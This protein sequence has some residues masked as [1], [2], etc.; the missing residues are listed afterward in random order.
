MK[1]T[2]QPWMAQTM[3]PPL[4]CSPFKPIVKFFICRIK[5]LRF[6]R[7]LL[8]KSSKQSKRGR[9][10]SASNLDSAQRTDGRRGNSQPHN[11][12][13]PQA[14]DPNLH[15]DTS[16]DTIF[17]ITGNYVERAGARFYT[18][19]EVIPAELAVMDANTGST[20][21]S[22]TVALPYRLRKI[23]FKRTHLLRRMKKHKY[24]ASTVPL[25]VAAVRVLFEQGAGHAIR[26]QEEK[27]VKGSEQQQHGSITDGIAHIAPWRVYSTAGAKSRQAWLAKQSAATTR[28]ITNSSPKRDMRGG[29][30]EQDNA[31]RGFCSSL[32]RVPPQYWPKNY[33]AHVAAMGLYD[34]EE[35]DEECD[36]LSNLSTTASLDQEEVSRSARSSEDGMVWDNVE[37]KHHDEQDWPALVRVLSRRDGIYTPRSI[38]RPVKSPRKENGQQPKIHTFEEKTPGVCGLF[39]SIRTCLCGPSSR[40]P[41]PVAA[42]KPRV[43][44]ELVQSEQKQGFKQSWSQKKAAKIVSK[45]RE[46]QTNESEK[47]AHTYLEDTAPKISANPNTDST[48]EKSA[49]IRSVPQSRSTSSDSHSSGSTRS[50]SS[51]RL[52]RTSSYHDLRQLRFV[53]SPEKSVQTKGIVKTAVSF[54]NGTSCSAPPKPALIQDN[55]P[56]SL[57]RG[58]PEPT[59]TAPPHLYH[60]ALN[61]SPETPSPPPY[62]YYNALNPAPTPTPTLQSTQPLQSAQKD[63]SALK[64]LISPSTRA[65]LAQVDH[66]TS[67]LARAN[68]HVHFADDRETDRNTSSTRIY[69]RPAQLN[70]PLPPV[71]SSHVELPWNPYFDPHDPDGIVK[72]CRERLDAVSRAAADEARRDIERQRQ[73]RLVLEQMR[74]MEERD[75]NKNETVHGRSGGSGGGRKK[76]NAKR[77]ENPRARRIPM[78]MRVP[79]VF[80]SFPP[81]REGDDMNGGGGVERV[82]R[83]IDV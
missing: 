61:P 46:K 51:R 42:N 12:S 14:N 29:G 65:I 63:L 33:R 37:E 75:R 25:H 48:N 66:D 68:R 27:E 38:P 69:R 9:R 53:N 13:M 78:A 79:D 56:S 3:G 15:T 31:L 60:N 57:P 20:T 28:S 62:L 59:F 54:Q 73:G 35:E 81:F 39:H 4:T 8:S 45:L 16:A 72:Q 23:G 43:G 55:A 50:D 6:V 71:P 36:D 30:E 74:R 17:P 7:W 11:H 64:T 41:V 77:L 80:T 44:I 58:F 34:W 2:P 70:N 47:E 67:Q 32:D 52:V 76:G 1:P 26:E 21:S 19:E 5:R 83:I 82:E 22:L 40:I 10:A 18:H 24:L 49:W